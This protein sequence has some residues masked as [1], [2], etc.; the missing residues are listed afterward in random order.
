M[1]IGAF[2]NY[3]L[4][5]GLAGRRQSCKKVKSAFSPIDR[6]IW[7]HAASLGEYE[8]GLAV[9]EKLKANFP[10]HKILITFFFFFV[11]ENVI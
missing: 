8:Q 7:M 1:K 2:F 9:L 11:Y 6:V 3:K 4:K 10:E 5:K